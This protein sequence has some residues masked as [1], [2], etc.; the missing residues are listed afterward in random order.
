METSTE[1]TE[2]AERIQCRFCGTEIEGRRDKVYCSDRCRKADARRS[3]ETEVD[4]VSQDVEGPG[5]DSPVESKVIEGADGFE[6]KEVQ[7]SVHGS[8]FFS[9]RY[10]S[11]PGFDR[12]SGQCAECAAEE[13]L[14]QRAKELLPQRQKE[15]Q[16]RMGA[17]LSRLEEEIQRQTADQV[18][19]WVR[20]VRPQIEAGVREHYWEQVRSRA[21]S[22]M[23]G[24]IVEELRQA[25]G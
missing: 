1:R 8:W 2:T 18:E 19:Q 24:E 16:R 11:L 7:C 25:G 4:A 6:G 12:W 5:P 20:E 13:K 22:E 9:W 10:R 14:E 15:I 21:E 23:I 17:E 3:T